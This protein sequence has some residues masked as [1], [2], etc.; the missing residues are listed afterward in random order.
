M[1]M[2]IQCNACEMAEASVMCCADEAALCRACDE[3]IHSANKL[4]SKH[5]RVPLSNSPSQMPNCD[6]CQVSILEFLKVGFSGF[7]KWNCLYL[8]F[9]FNLMGFCFIC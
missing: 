4:A 5:L 8:C 6:I 9:R 3:K 2:K 7:V 1:R